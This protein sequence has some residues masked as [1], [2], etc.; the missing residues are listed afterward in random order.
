MSFFLFLLVNA[1]LFIRPAE[2]VPAVQGWRIYEALIIACLV[3]ALPEIVNHLLGRSLG[4]QPVTLAVFGLLA[5]VFLSHASQ[6]DIEKAGE[7]GFEFLKLVL[8]YLLLVSVVNTPGRL[9]TFL[10]CIVG[11]CG[12][13]ALVTLLNYHGVVEIKLPPPAV[14]PDKPGSRLEPTASGSIKEFVFD[15]QRGD[16]VALDR[17]RGTGIFQ[18][19]NDICLA[20]VIAVPLCLYWLTDRRLGALRLL[21]L[22]PVGL[23]CVLLYHTHSRGGFLGF[24]AG[25]LALF[26]ARFGWRRTLAVCAGA[27]PVLL[28]AFA[29]RMT[30]IEAGGGTGQ[31][32]IQLWSDS[33]EHFR[34]APLLGIGMDE[35]GTRMSHVSHNS[36]IQGYAEMG[37][38]GG[39]LFLGAFYCA[40]LMLARAGRAVPVVSAETARLR[41]YLL[42]ILVGSAMC[43]L[44]L[45]LNYIVP[46]Y[47]VLG[48]ATAYLAVALPRTARP[49][50][51]LDIPL[52][53][54]LAVVSVGFLAASYVFVRL[55]VRW[56]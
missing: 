14:A 38:F 15:A 42:A 9:R 52:L 25:L 19:P 7:R 1:T 12:V 2:V 24:L 17:L 48:L 4:T 18:D 43:M 26:H 30:S 16:L 39:T 45:S 31:S 41:P 33:L 37:V 5:A 32:R 46:T 53:Q 40:L 56:A 10:F 3:V 27:I 6:M 36:F 13:M 50:V 21:W 55:L 49:V 35:I 44:T 34:E 22:A 29:G 51:S 47:M 23:F 28:V 11:F 54:R 20:V 8:Y